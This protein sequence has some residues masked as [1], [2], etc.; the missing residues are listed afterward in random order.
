MVPPLPQSP[1]RSRSCTE[2]CAWVALDNGRWS[3]RKRDWARR[4]LL[5]NAHSHFWQTSE[6]TEQQLSEEHTNFEQSM[7]QQKM[8]WGT[9]DQNLSPGPELEGGQNEKN[10][11]NFEQNQTLS[12]FWAKSV[13]LLTS[14]QFLLKQCSNVAP[15]L[16]GLNHRHEMIGNLMFGGLGNFLGRGGPG[17]AQT[18]C[19]SDSWWSLF[20][21]VVII[22]W[23]WVHEFVATL[24][25]KGNRNTSWRSGTLWDTISWWN[26]L[27]LDFNLSLWNTGNHH[28]LNTFSVTNT[29]PQMQNSKWVEKFG[30][31]Q[32]CSQELRKFPCHG[33][34]FWARVASNNQQISAYCWENS[35]IFEKW[36][37]EILL[38]WGG[39]PF[40]FVIV[41]NDLISFCIGTNLANMLCTRNCYQ[42][43]LVSPLF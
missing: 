3:Y 26:S 21:F 19:W 7:S 8:N 22:F 10:K 40:P 36:G 28:C 43:G 18:T 25:W 37:N 41:C 16:W 42:V 6:Q 20:H 5:T 1:P 11:R 35:H 34:L 33:G 31:R 17:F 2:Q 32:R 9:F 38:L 24:Y 39:F 30:P 13:V 27:S 14:V 4:T 15:M 12:K 23:S 29:S